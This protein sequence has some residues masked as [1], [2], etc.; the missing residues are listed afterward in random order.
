MPDVAAPTVEQRLAVRA[1]MLGQSPSDDAAEASIDR[2]LELTPTVI[3]QAQTQPAPTRTA[4]TEQRET[5]R[6]GRG[7][8]DFGW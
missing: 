3:E 6:G 5:D 2:I 8:Y 1:W 4:E 7:G